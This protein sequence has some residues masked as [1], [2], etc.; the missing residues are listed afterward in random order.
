MGKFR[1]YVPFGFHMKKSTLLTCLL[2]LCLARV[3]AT[4]F[5]VAPNGD[6]ANRGTRDKPFGTVQRAQSAAGP[7]DTVYIRGG[8]YHLAEAQISHKERIY[9]CVTYLDKSGRPGKYI[10]YIAYPGER[11][12][13]DY[14]AVK[15]ADY[16]VA[17]FYITGSWLHLKGFEVTGRVFR[18]PRQQQYLRATKHARWDGHRVLP[19]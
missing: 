15:P 3:S 6:D 11:P 9:A 14:T 19:P 18:E 4:V 1:E 10:T 12:V 8:V 16:R 7:G 13:F 17:A 5:F 2:L